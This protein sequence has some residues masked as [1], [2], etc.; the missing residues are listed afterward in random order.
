MELVGIAAL[1][2]TF[3]CVEKTWKDRIKL[4]MPVKIPASKRGLAHTFDSVDVANWLLSQASN[5]DEDVNPAV[6][7][8]LLDR[9]RRRVVDLD[10]ETKRALLIPADVVEATWSGMTSAARQRLLAIPYRIAMAA[11][12][13]DGNFARIE[14]AATEL[15]REALEELHAYDAND[16]A[17]GKRGMAVSAAAETHREPV[18]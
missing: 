10:Y 3:G 6:E 7:K 18:G 5:G 9:A 13:A 1:T 15:V 17:P 12:S 2:D 4:G 11:Q 16:Y 8:A 14:S